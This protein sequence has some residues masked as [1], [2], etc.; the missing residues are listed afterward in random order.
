MTAEQFIQYK[1]GKSSQQMEADR[2]NF[3]PTFVVRLMEEYAIAKKYKT[4]TQYYESKNRE[5]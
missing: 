1:L 4:I 2:Q 5:G 3:S